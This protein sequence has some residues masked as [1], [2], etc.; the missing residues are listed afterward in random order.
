MNYFFEII[1]KDKCLGV[2]EVPADDLDEFLSGD[3]S[4]QS[5]RLLAVVP[6]A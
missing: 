2:Q 4:P 1:H 6:S 5:Y 3:W